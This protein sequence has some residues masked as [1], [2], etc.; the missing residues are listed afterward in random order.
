M[1]WLQL[2]TERI[3]VRVD[4]LSP[5]K[6]ANKYFPK[7]ITIFHFD[8]DKKATRATMTPLTLLVSSRFSTVINDLYQNKVFCTILMS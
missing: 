7:C 3:N 5:D 2:H 4:E 6:K 1:S 8:K